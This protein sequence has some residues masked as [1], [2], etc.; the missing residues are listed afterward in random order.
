MALLTDIEFTQI[1]SCPHPDLGVRPDNGDNLGNYELLTLELYLWF[2][3][4][5]LIYTHTQ[6]PWMHEIQ[7]YISLRQQHRPPYL[8]TRPTFHIVGKISRSA[9]DN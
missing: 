7:S 5:R 3:V 1:S 9:S 6:V 2:R 8:S 4:I